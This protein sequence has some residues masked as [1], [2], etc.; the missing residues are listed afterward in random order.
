MLD[1]LEDIAEDEPKRLKRRFTTGKGPRAGARRCRL[2]RA[3][4]ASPAPR[5]GCPGAARLAALRRRGGVSVRLPLFIW[6]PVPVQPARHGR[7]ARRC[8][9]RVGAGAV[10]RLSPLRS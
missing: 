6:M 3:L 4:A 1:L 10:Q 7:G 5:A 8:P 9:A 2:T